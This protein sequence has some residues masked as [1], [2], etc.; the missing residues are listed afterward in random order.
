L[1]K[2]FRVEGGSS[3]KLARPTI[4]R[5]TAREES[6]SRPLNRLQRC[7]Q[8]LFEVEWISAAA[9]LDLPGDSDESVGCVS[10]ASLIKVRTSAMESGS[11]CKTLRQARQQ[12]CKRRW[13][14][15][16]WEK[17]RSKREQ[18][19]HRKLRDASA[20]MPDQFPV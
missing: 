14:L 17:L 7:T 18:E 4:E 10:R 8:L 20:D 9:L 5:R 12:V 13:E 1:V 3:A 2:T 16:V 11:S 15:A 19:E 6:R